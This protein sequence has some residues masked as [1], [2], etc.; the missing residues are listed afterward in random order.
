MK[1]NLTIEEIKILKT[2]LES[3]QKWYEFFGDN[4]KDLKKFHN[5]LDNI[6][7]KLCASQTG[8]I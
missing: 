7:L 3:E 5:K 8:K 1:I 2:M 6:L 4:N